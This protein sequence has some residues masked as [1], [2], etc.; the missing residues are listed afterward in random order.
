MQLGRA[1]GQVQLGIHLPSTHLDL[2]DTGST[3]D[4]GGEVGDFISAYGNED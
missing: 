2:V 1:I 3:S 4:M